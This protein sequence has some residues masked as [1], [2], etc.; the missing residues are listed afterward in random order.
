MPQATATSHS[1]RR[2]HD[3]E[4]VALAVP[5][6]GA[7]VA[8]PLFVMVDSAIVGHLGTPQLAGLGV[9]AAL[10]TTAVSIF[11]FLAYATTAAVA[12]RV[13]AGDLA[14]AIR[15]GMDGIWLALLLGIAVIAVALPSAPW[16]VEIFGASDT[17]APYATTYL[18]ISSL[19]IPA[20]LIVMAATGVLRGLQDTRT[21]LYVAIGGFAANGTLNAGLVYGAGLGIAGSAWGTV[22]AQV[23]MA[24]AYLIVVVRGARRHGASLRPDTAGIRAS[25]QAGV[26]LLVRTLSL[27]G[28]LMIATAVAARLG[29]TDIAA[30][31]IILSLWS[32]MAFALDA[33]A[34]A[35]Q[36]IIGR[37]LGAN[38]TEGA[39]EACRRMVQWGIASGVVLGALIVLARPLFIPLFTG[40]QDVQSILLPALLVA[41]VC[42]PIAGVV[43]VLDGVLMGAGDGRYLAW[44]MLITLAVFAPVAL[45]VPTYG[46]GLTALWWAMALMMTVRMVTLWLRTRSGKWIV[47]GATR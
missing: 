18:R 33:I 43:F 1:S 2:R 38:D 21:P 9:A 35:G 17:A 6:F 26:P 45:L 12:R 5:A 3:R 47:T 44:A 34:I 32:L 42:Q 28:V 19:G 11:V 29:D 46:G 25:A 14:S 23:G 27:R 39:R 22:I 16:L 7:L 37:Y 15:Q 10:L 24:S 4:I 36:A 40:D 8:E 13:G 31:Q 41:A 20:M 30:H